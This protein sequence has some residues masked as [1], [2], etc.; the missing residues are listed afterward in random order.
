MGDNK[1]LV[2]KRTSVNTLSS[3]ACTLGGRSVINQGN[4]KKLAVDNNATPAPRK[5]VC[6]FK[7]IFYYPK[8]DEVPSGKYFSKIYDACLGF[9]KYNREVMDVYYVLQPE[10]EC[11]KKE[12]G[13][14]T[15]E[16]TEH[17]VKQR[18]VVGSERYDRMI[19]SV[20]AS[21][22]IGYNEEFNVEDMV[23]ATERVLL[24]YSGEDCIGGFEKRIAW[25]LK[26][27]I[28]VR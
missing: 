7:S 10:V 22:G 26:K 17:Y 6:T 4:V 21:L 11:F 23:G 16:T 5:L 14:T 18:Y 1:K 20:T 28:D 13:M 8:E 9:D 12:N 3:K 15:D 19:E 2:L 27:Y 25:T 24:T